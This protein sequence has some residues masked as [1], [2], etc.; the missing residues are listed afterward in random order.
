[1]IPG[2]EW[3]DAKAATNK[4]KHGVTFREAT[5]VFSDAVAVI[6]DDSDHSEHECREI[7]IGFS[8]RFRLLV[9]SFTQR[10]DNVRIISARKATRREQERYEENTGHE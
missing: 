9:V 6:F 2:F 4:R 10:G 7:I 5:T 1:M 3:D 8:E